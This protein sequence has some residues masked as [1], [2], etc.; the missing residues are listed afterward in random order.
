[1]IWQNLVVLA[2]FVGV[3]GF[4]AYAGDLL[5]RRMGKRRLTLFGMR[6]RYTAIMTTTVT[7][8]LI[9]AFT[10]TIMAMTSKD[11]RDLALRGA[12]IVHE[13]RAAQA[14]VKKAKKEVIQQ[15]HIAVK[16][17]KE[18]AAAVKQRDLVNAEIAKLK[19]SLDKL[20]A[21]LKSAKKEIVERTAQIAELAK[22]K[23]RLENAFISGYADL[24]SEKVVFQGG[25]EIDRRVI[26][27]AQSKSGIRA[28]LEK[29]LGQVSRTASVKGAKVGKN[30]RAIRFVPK[31]IG[32]GPIYNEPAIINTII[33]QIYSGTGK[34]VV[35]VRS[36]TN[37]FAGEQAVID[38][39]LYQNQL[40]YLKGEAVSS[41]TI[42]GSD[43]RGQIFENLIAFLKSEVRDTAEKK[44]V[45]PS[46]DEEGNP[47]VG[48]IAWDEIFDL[49][50]HIKTTGKSVR[51]KAL[52]ADETWSAGPLDLKLVVSESP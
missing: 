12:A 44:G 48:Q 30:G 36:R 6:P 42:D 31:Q 11:M 40:I 52:A 9:A 20:H 1:M 3:C 2:V 50:D 34:T 16:A 15:R 13:Y 18:A 17:Q 21:D 7:G 4:I 37:S 14:E 5:G 49:V 45:M 32:E 29:L 10:I 33:N 8:M 28:D 22:K 47:S 39:K 26:I 41:T 46:Y 23:Q 38:C 19:K 43:S 35:I 24:H 51:V 27:C 25:K